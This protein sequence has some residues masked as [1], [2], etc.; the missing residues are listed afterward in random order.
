MSYN[1]NNP[2]KNRKM[3]ETSQKNEFD[4]KNK[5]SNPKTLKFGVTWLNT[6]KQFEKNNKTTFNAIADLWE[7]YCTL[8]ININFEKTIQGWGQE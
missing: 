6:I 3:W 2:K 7:I 5:K 8:N 4:L 1:K